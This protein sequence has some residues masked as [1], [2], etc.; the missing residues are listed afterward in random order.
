MKKF[1]LLPALV[2]AGCLLSGCM[3]LVVV[4]PKEKCVTRFCLGERGSLT[5]GPAAA[6]PLTA[7]DVLAR[8]GAP[9]NIQTNAEAQAV[10]HYRGPRN[11]SFV[12][13]AY[14]IGCP[15]PVASSHDE[16]DIYFKDGVARKARSTVLV[17]SGAMIGMCPA[18][19]VV[20]WEKEP[21]PKCGTVVIGYG[22]LE[23]EEPTTSP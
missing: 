12:M 11:W 13:P 2:L 20:A 14:V 5:N 9:D 22:L 23:E 4:H 17:V 10:W 7:A 18:M 1:I 8:W 3:G 6:A 21:E 19:V 15:I 16:V